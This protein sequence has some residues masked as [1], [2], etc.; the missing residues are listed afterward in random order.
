MSLY[1]RLSACA[2]LLCL[3][4][5][6]T[7]PRVVLGREE[8]RAHPIAGQPRIGTVFTGSVPM[9]GRQVPLP[10]GD[11]TVLTV[12]SRRNIDT[13]QQSGSVALVQRDGPLLQG[14]VQAVIADRRMVAA[15]ELPPICTSS[16]VLWNDIRQAV[17][18]GPKDCSAIYFERPDLWWVSYFSLPSQVLQNLRE[19]DMRLPRVVVALHLYEEGAGPVLTESVALN[20]DARGIAPDL[21]MTRGR[22]SWTAFALATDP[23][24][25]QL[26]GDLKSLAPPLRAALR[27]QAESTAPFGSL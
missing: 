27:A 23:A 3:L 22:S 6:C 11:W 21:Y 20:P 4:A 14:I 10:G 17:P 16:D 8:F 24:K 2:A 15:N 13:G 9:F 18:F 12:Q 7:P 25:Q 1:G 19:S 26:L 5:A